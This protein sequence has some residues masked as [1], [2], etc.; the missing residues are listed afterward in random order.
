MLEC[1]FVSTTLATKSWLGIRVTGSREFPPM[2]RDIFGG[3]F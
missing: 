2:G 1:V 3:I